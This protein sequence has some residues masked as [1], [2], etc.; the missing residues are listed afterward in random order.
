VVRVALRTGWRVE[1]IEAAEF[2]IN[3]DPGIALAWRST[4]TRA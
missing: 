4:I 2:E 3:L 1:S